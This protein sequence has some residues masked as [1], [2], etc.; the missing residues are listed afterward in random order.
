MN[1]RSCLPAGSCRSPCHFWRTRPKIPHGSPC[2]ARS[3]C[4]SDRVLQRPYGNRGRLA[5]LQERPEGEPGSPRGSHARVLEYGNCGTTRRR[6]S[7]RLSRRDHAGSSKRRPSQQRPGAG[8]RATGGRPNRRNMSI[9]RREHE[10]Y[11]VNPRLRR[12]KLLARPIRRPCQCSQ[13]SPEGPEVCSLTGYE[14]LV[15][16]R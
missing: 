4:S 12:P 7:S 16:G 6:S 3:S 5:R 1:E 11:A 8:K 13:I 15:F 10:G 9:V 14:G 2:L